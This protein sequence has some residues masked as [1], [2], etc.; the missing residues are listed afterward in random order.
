M[1]Q[2]NLKKKLVKGSAIV[3]TGQFYQNSFIDKN[4]NEKTV[5][6][7]NLHSITLPVCDHPSDNTGE[8]ESFDDNDIIADTDP[9]VASDEISSKHDLLTETKYSKRSKK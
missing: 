2:E 5:N 7:I 4:K 1:T 6:C 9:R 3:I 8:F